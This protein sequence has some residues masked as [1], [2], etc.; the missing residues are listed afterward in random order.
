VLAYVATK[1]QF[2]NDAPTIQDIVREQVRKNLNLRVGE[3][4]Y[5]SWRNSLG[6]SMANVMRD[7]EIPADA[8]VAIEYRPNGRNFRIDFMISGQDRA[9]DRFPTYGSHSADQS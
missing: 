1:E 8:G 6:N 9:E 4:E 2:L 3:N 5:R 7:S